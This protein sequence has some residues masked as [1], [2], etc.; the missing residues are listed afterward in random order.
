MEII[1]SNL[2]IITTLI[3]NNFWMVLLIIALLLSNEYRVI[4]LILLIY[5]ALRGEFP[6]PILSGIILVVLLGIS[7]TYDKKKF[8]EECRNDYNRKLGELM[9]SLMSN[10][11]DRKDDT[12]K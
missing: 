10:N 5:P 12:I 7:F 3:A 11:K 9:L 6:N 2:A 4:G 1:L 8:E